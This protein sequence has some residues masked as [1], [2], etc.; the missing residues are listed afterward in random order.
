[1][2]AGPAAM[3]GPYEDE[4]TRAGAESD[5]G[6]DPGTERGARSR[7]EVCPP[8]GDAALNTLFAAA[9]PGHE[10]T[11]FGARLRHSLLWVAAFRGE[12]LTGFVNVV[13]DGGVHAFVLDTTVHPSARRRGLGV[14]LVR[15]AADEARRAGARW[16]HVDYEPHLTGF[17]ERCGFAPTAAGLRRLG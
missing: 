1:M 3:N 4:R 14:R 8:L 7:L 2:R 16:L 12:E 11:D 5:A 10:P 6:T 15:R 9:W 13:G 17:Y